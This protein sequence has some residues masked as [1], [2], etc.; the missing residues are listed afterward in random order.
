MQVREIR[1]PYHEATGPCKARKLGQSL[2][3]GE[4]YWLQIDAHMQCLPGWDTRLKTMLCQ[5]E[6]QSEF[7]KA[8]ISSYPPDYEGTGPVDVFP[9]QNLPVVLC[10]ERFDDQGIAICSMTS[11]LACSDA[12]GSNPMDVRILVFI[13][14]EQQQ[15]W[16]AGM[17]R[18][19]GKMMSQPF[20]KPLRSLFWAAGFSFARSKLFEEVPY[21]D[22]PHLFF[23]EEL[24][25]L[26]RMWTAGWDV[27]APNDIIFFHQWSRLTRPT[28]WKVI[29]A[30]G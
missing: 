23:G 12:L 1:I 11:V 28:V 7:A 2:W 9:T 8:V 4:E 14:Q 25:M 21:I 30:V 18:L 17:L 20:C 19:T 16:A 5:A 26:L 15:T 6:E 3:N 29:I 13:N 10:A 27:F 24:F 22:L